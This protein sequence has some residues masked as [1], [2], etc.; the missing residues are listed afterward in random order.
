MG[1]SVDAR[2]RARALGAR[3]RLCRCFS[4]V[5]RVEVLGAVIAATLLVGC[6]AG[7][8][9][10]LKMSAAARAGDGS[11]IAR[12]KMVDAINRTV[13]AGT[14]TAKLHMTASY[15]DG[16][17][18]ATGSGVLNLSPEA[19]QFQLVED[20]GQSLLGNRLMLVGGEA[21]ET[22]PRLADLE[23]GK[24]WVSVDASASSAAGAP[25]FAVMYLAAD[26][27]TLLELLSIP[28][29]DA[30]SVGPTSENGLDVR[31]YWVTLSVSALQNLVGRHDLS[32]PL[33]L[34]GRTAIS[35]LTAQIYVDHRG[36]IAE[37]DI[38]TQIGEPE[39][40]SI[41]CSVDFT[42]FG[43][44]VHITAP[45]ATTVIPYPQLERDLA[46]RQRI[47]A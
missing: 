44:R 2:R 10:P 29:S 25:I 32:M 3:R 34:L 22:V 21:Y 30:R 41:T 13:A 42:L 12:E 37:V 7:S 8:H 18:S 15:Y 31:G 36:T 14:A 43:P 16:L 20:D 24:T 38:M 28:G 4:L 47:P 6:S 39:F 35:S 1:N 9:R 5:V 46:A 19:A 11:P 23:P 33:Q 45:A 17:V 27:A 26:P 40:L